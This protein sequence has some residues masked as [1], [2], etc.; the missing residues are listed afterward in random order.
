M[1]RARVGWTMFD[2]D[3]FGGVGVA[4]SA[5]RPPR[6]PRRRSPLPGSSGVAIPE[7]PGRGP[8]RP[9]PRTTPHLRREEG[10]GGRA[11]ERG[12]L[13]LVRS[14]DPS[15]PRSLLNGIGF[16][17][18]LQALETAGSVAKYTCEPQPRNQSPLGNVWITIG[19]F[20]AGSD[21]P[22][23]AGCL[24]GSLAVELSFR[25]GQ[26]RSGGVHRPARTAALAGTEGIAG[27]APGRGH[28]LAPSSAAAPSKTGAPV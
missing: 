26:S 17:T 7:V 5:P 6:S 21:R 1:T 27:L 8:R 16:L 10:V 12:L 14:S 2:R 11:S 20:L 19:L 15:A 22:V 18:R 13:A 24:I 23:T 3:A 4:Q 9:P 28:A 25:G